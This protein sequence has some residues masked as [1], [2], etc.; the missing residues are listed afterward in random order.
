MQPIRFN[1]ENLL[2]APLTTWTCYDKKEEKEVQVQIEEAFSR[3]NL[4]E[5]K[6]LLNNQTL[7]TGRAEI[8]FRDIPVSAVQHNQNP[9]K[10]CCLHISH[11]K[12]ELPDCYTGI[13]RI[14]YVAFVN[15]SLRKG[16]KGRILVSADY[17]SHEF[18][19][20]CGSTP[21][22][23]ATWTRKAWNDIL[24]RKKKVCRKSK[25]GTE[26]AWVEKTPE[27]KLL[28]ERT[29]A[30]WAALQ[31]LDK[32]LKT[33]TKDDEEIK[34]Q[35]QAL[36]AS[37]LDHSIETREFQKFWPIYKDVRLKITQTAEKTRKQTGTPNTWKLG[38]IEMFLPIDQIKNDIELFKQKDLA[39]LSNES[40]PILTS[41]SIYT[42]VTSELNNLI[43]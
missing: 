27:E 43:N 32:R 36:I 26:Y 4:W 5:I 22:P 30:K 13:G 1:K 15:L 8:Q 14:L 24:C 34:Q 3:G 10:K 40:L 35:A 7:G 38:C 9:T 33:Q 42:Q 23:T 16:L 12:N 11:M 31:A 37:I 6:V 21:I 28:G 29:R 20:K 18:H 41:D 39:R 17:S 2:I 25:E 19:L